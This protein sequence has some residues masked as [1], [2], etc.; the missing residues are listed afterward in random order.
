M[1]IEIFFKEIADVRLKKITGFP[2]FLLLCWLMHKTANYKL[3]K[4]PEE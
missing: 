2:L 1:T 3:P 4:K